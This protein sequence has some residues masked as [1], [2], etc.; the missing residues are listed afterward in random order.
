VIGVLTASDVPGENDISSPHLHDEPVFAT[1]RVEYWGQALFAVIGVTR[2]AARRASRLAR[3]AYRDLP[4][5]LD[6]DAARAAGGRL[7]TEPLKLERGDV[8][9]GLAAAPRR[10]K[11]TMRIGGQEHFYL[12]GQVALAIPGEDEDVTV[13]ASSQHPSEVQLMIAHV[14][15]ID[16]HAV[17]VNVRRMGGGFGGKESQGNLY[18]VV[19][20]LAAKHF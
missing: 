4:P 15:G 12:E 10:I 18:A 5:L 11:G 2:E 17:T 9:A 1:G 19:A 6:V 20:A 8:E 7:V 3:I 16:Q 14:L 13:H